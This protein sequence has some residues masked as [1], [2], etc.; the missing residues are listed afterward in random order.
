MTIA[1]QQARAWRYFDPNR[2]RQNFIPGETDVDATRRLVLQAVKRQ[3]VSDVPVGCFLSGGMDSA[4]IAAAMRQV[5]EEKQEILTFSIGFD[6]PRYDETAAAQSVAT[7]LKTRHQA[8]HVTLDA[9]EDLNRIVRSFGQPFADSSA[10]PT[11]HLSQV[12]RQM[13]KVALSGDGGD[14]LFGGYD[15]YRAMRLSGS[16]HPAVRYVLSRPVW[17]GLPGAH[18]KSRMARMKRLVKPMMLPPGQRYA[19]YM[20]LFSPDEV[21]HLMLGGAA[22][23]G[24]LAGL[25][26]ELL[27][28]RGEVQTALAVDRLTYLPEDLLVKVDRASMQHA[29][30]VR[31]PFLDTDVVQ[32]AAGLDTGQLLGRGSKSLLRHAFAADMPAGHFDRP[33]MGFAVPI[34][35][36]LRTDLREM[37]HDSIAAEG[38]FASQFF[39][40]K[41]IAQMVSEH[42][43]STRDHS[44][45]LYA[46]LV[47]ELWLTNRQ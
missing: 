47:L 1:L 42:E 31:R 26:G 6:D 34:G 23:E 5:S 16:L 9:V 39:D 10:I 13:V 2:A 18:P 17:Q 4:I 15:R 28:G 35:E 38:S 40:R 32:F 12:T 3:L 20:E 11:Y 29:L 30:E 44:Q 24:Y 41:Y 43:S 22:G 25:Y 46:L 45:R 8:F 37:L 27:P 14:E 19:R 21:N 33:K 36:W 7:H